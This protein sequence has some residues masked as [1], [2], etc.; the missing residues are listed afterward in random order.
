MLGLGE[1]EQEVVQVLQD[2]RRVGVDLVTIGQYLR[3][4][5]DHLP[6]YRYVL[7]EEFEAYRSLALEMGFRGAAC[8]PLVRSSYHADEH[9]IKLRPSRVQAKKTCSNRCC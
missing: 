8:G 6:V 7:P 9:A 3:P 5:P 4:S 2:W 1:R